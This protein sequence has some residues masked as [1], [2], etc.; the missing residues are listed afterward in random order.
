MLGLAEIELEYRAERQAAGIAVAKSKGKYKG[1]KHGSH[2]A[3]PDRA[4]ELRGKGLKVDEIANA[5]GVS[6][7]TVLRYLRMAD[8]AKVE[9]FPPQVTD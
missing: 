2:K 3:K 6:R 5:M 8:H 9:T 7:R 4:Q 1:R